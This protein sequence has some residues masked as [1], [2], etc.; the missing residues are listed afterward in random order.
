MVL[1]DTSIWSL[2]L[3]RRATALSADERRLVIEWEALV[4]RGRATLIGPIRQEI[5]SGVRHVDTFHV[6]RRSLL[7]FPHL[8][9]EVED[10][11]RAAEFFNLCRGRGSSGGPI[12]MLIAAVAYRHQISVFSSDTDYARYARHVPVRLHT[13]QPRR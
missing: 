4:D 9:I 5:L 10:Y 2:A 8:S 11:D 13:P 7:D 12:D 6:L 1:V 3:R